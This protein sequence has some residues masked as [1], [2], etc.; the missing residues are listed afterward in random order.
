LA[1][2]FRGSGSNTARWRAFQTPAGP[3]PRPIGVRPARTTPT[4]PPRRP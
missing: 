2:P 4:T 3:T 1:R